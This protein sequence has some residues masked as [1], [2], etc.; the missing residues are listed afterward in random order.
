MND[1]WIAKFQ[2]MLVRLVSLS[3]LAGIAIAGKQI[4]KNI[5][6]TDSAEVYFQEGY[7]LLC[8][9]KYDDA[10]AKFDRALTLDSTHLLSLCFKAVALSDL[11][12]FPEA[13]KASDSILAVYSD[14]VFAF[15]V[16]A[17]ALKGLWREF[18]SERVINQALAIPVKETD[19]LSY[20]GRGL[21]YY[22]QGENSQAIVEFSKAIKLTPKYG[23]AYAYVNRG[24]AYYNQKEHKRALADF[25]K[26]ISL[27]SK[28]AVA[29]LGRGL[30]YNA[31]GDH[32]RARKEYQK[33]IDLG[34][35]GC[36]LGGARYSL[37]LL[38]SKK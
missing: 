37:K 2:V 23:L 6:K 13:I 10:I 5:G 14:C 19:W 38:E 18:E 34:A 26:A 22:I 20:L 33:V 21:A 36:V 12:R 28:F 24:F 15:A 35:T 31:L 4:G 29:Y 30:V 3:L 32:K 9:A 7:K 1:N 8:Q 25:N 16:K 27:N 17:G 11:E